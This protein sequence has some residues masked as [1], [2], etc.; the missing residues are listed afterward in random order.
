MESTELATVQQL[1]PIYVDVTQSSSDFM[2]LKRSV[3]Q[4][5]LHKDSARSTVQLVMENGQVYPIKGTLQF[6]TLP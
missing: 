5:N 4:G 1:G 2:R 6:P 3:E